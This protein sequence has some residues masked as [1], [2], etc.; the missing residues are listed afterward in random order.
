MAN[1]NTV[2]NQLFENI[3]C[4]INDKVSAPSQIILMSKSFLG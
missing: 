2:I 1:E 3:I 4:T